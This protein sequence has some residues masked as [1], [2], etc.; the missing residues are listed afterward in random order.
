LYVGGWFTNAGGS[1]VT[2]IAKWDGSSWSAL[3][4]G[5]N[6]DVSALAI[7]GNELYAGGY[8]TTAGG[9][10]AYSVAKW[11][12]SNW[13]ALGSGMGGGDGPSVS[14]LAVSGGDLYAAGDFTTADGSTANSI[15]K[16]NGS[17]WSPL[18]SGMNYQRVY[19][20]AVSGS[21]L[22]YAGGSFT[23]AGGSAANHI[24]QWNGSSW[25]VLGPVGLGINGNVS[26]LAVSGS[27]VYAGGD[28]T[29]ADG[30]AGNKVAKWNGTS[31]SA[32]GSGMNNSVR[33]LAVSGSNL[34]AGGMF[35]T[36]DGNVVN[37][38]AKWDGSSWSALGSGIN[39]YV[40][41]VAA[42]GSNVYAGGHFTTAG[43]IAANNIAKWNGSTWSAL[44]SGMGGSFPFV[45]AVVVSGN[46]LYAGGEFTTAGGVAAN[47][48]AKW[49]G[50]S[51][52][53]L[54]SGLNDDVWALAVSGSNVYAGG[55]F[56]MA[57][58]I[59]AKGIAK[60]DGSSWSALG[61]GMNSWVLALAAS[62]NDLY[63]GGFFTTAGGYPANHIA[64]WNGT[65]WS[66]LGSG[67][68]EAVDV[69]TVSGGSLYAG[70]RFTTAGGKVSAYV[71]KA[72]IDNLDVRCPAPEIA[73]EQPA[74]V[75]LVDGVSSVDFGRASLG[76]RTQRTFTIR[77]TGIDDFAVLSFTIDGANAAEFAVAASPPIVLPPGGSTTFTVTFGAVA[78]GV[79]VAALHIFSSEADQNP[80]DVTLTA[81]APLTGFVQNTLV[82]TITSPVP[83]NVINFG[84]SVAALGSDRVIVGA[85][86]VWTGDEHD[87]GVAYL[88]NT[89]GTSL[90]TFTNPAPQ[91]YDEF[92]AS[93]AV[94]GSDRVF[95]GARGYSAYYPAGGYYIS[96]SGVV[97]LFNTNG[98]LLN[99]IT[100]PT[101]SSDEEFGAHI[102]A[103][104]S[105]YLLVGGPY[106]YDPSIGFHTGVAYLFS[107]NGILLTTFTN[108]APVTDDSYFGEAVAALGSD[109][110]MIT[111]PT[112]VYVFS[113]NGALLNTLFTPSASS[114]SL[115]VVGSNRVLVGV[116]YVGT[117]YLLDTNGTLLT[118]FPN[119]TPAYFERFGGAI[120]ALGSDRVMIG[121]M[122]S[123]AAPYSGAAYLFSAT[124]TLL[125][126]ITN[127][128]PAPNDLFGSSMAALGSDRVIIGA[129]SDDTAGTNTG[130]VYLFSLDP[131]APRL[132][133]TNT[134]GSVFV[135][136]TKAADDFV[137]DQSVTLG[138]WS[139][140]TTASYQT[141]ASSVFIS[142][143]APTDT[144][145]YR[146]RKSN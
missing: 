83:T 73:V 97:Y 42:S 106:E 79:R 131:V 49:N 26:A 2:N 72:T 16:W 92:G 119:P 61:S 19:A 44:G 144:K 54:G 29:T 109:R 8:F 141:N 57:G 75:S 58:G 113:T 1:P 102:A 107:T 25:S 55:N 100:N 105:D 139:Q 108:P 41:T 90:A 145:F 64:R 126:T 99:T 21:D 146:L 81:I 3:G 117:A 4:S 130:A 39:T 129:P 85:T 104:G 133:V 24:A 77:N 60:W 87:V 114:Y 59:A 9:S 62:G 116:P 140:V 50:S 14:A 28:F 110:V 18:G 46:D 34:Y 95:I 5:V 31:W 78:P 51:W 13:S 63:A 112:A 121:A 132:S 65:C 91:G 22:L 135:S 71:A 123:T 30:S 80:F 111:A 134:G 6:S 10:A 82:T 103:V 118:T 45:Y 12:G 35:T 27:D 138:A 86:T 74:G 33:E 88:F 94:L 53:A 69:L 84:R 76:S 124:S 11:N 96:D 38:T 127:P 98:T 143:P 52:S 70:G 122:D 37:K 115:A 17:T 7:S 47:H 136:W 23:T 20:L 125:T 142:V 43:G 89:N 40:Y 56:T 66:P 93:I 128:T 120:A 36:A 15:A 101:P 137:L 67:M 48:I 32:L 68:N